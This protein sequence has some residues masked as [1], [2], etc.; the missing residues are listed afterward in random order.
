MA[1]KESKEE[2]RRLRRAERLLENLSMPSRPDVLLDAVRTQAGFAPDPLA[3]TAVILK[4]MAL[5]AA[6]LHAAN[7]QLNGWKR[8]LI[9]I[10]GA[11]A[12]LGLERV[13]AIVAEQFLSATLVS[14]EGPLQMVRLRGVEAGRVAARLARELPKA[15]PHC[16][17]GYLPPVAPDEAYAAGLLHDCGLVAMM[18]GFPD[19]VGFCQEMHARGGGRRGGGGERA[20]RDQPLSGGFFD[21]AEM[22]SAGTFLS[23]HSHPS[24]DGRLQP[25]RT[26]GAGTRLYGSAGHTAPFRLGLRWGVGGGVAGRG[27]AHHLFFWFG[28]RAT[29]TIARPLRWGVRRR[30]WLFSEKYVSIWEM[31]RAGR[32]HRGT[33]LGG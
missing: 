3:V 25:S 24:S 19:Y 14:Q 11:V 18:R 23:D 16:L 17:N 13:R 31:K 4:D 15:A 28:S 33:F 9:S 5:S 26:E 1:A 30:G 20:F 8:K 10:E 12:L 27:R 6:V 21:G 2:H 29:G 7:T 22:A 32:I